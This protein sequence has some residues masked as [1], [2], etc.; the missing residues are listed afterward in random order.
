VTSGDAV[1]VV[2]AAVD[3]GAVED[4]THAASVPATRSPVTI[5][6]A[7]RVRVVTVRSLLESV[8]LLAIVVKECPPACCCRHP[9]PGVAVTFAPVA[10]H[11]VRPSLRSH[12]VPLLPAPGGSSCDPG[13]QRTGGRPANGRRRADGTG[14]APTPP[15]RPARSR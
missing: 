9:S 13:G 3:P 11:A 10:R 5:A 12:E 8:E 15:R 14:C 6:P 4:G 7:V 2:G 1:A